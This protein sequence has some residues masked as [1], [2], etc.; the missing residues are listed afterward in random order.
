MYFKDQTHGRELIRENMEHLKGLFP[1]LSIAD[2]G[3]AGGTPPPYSLV[4]EIVD[5]INFEPDNRI[6]PK[7]NLGEIQQV[8][9]GPKELNK[10]YLNKRP[11]TSS[12]LP[13]CHRVVDRYDFSQFKDVDGKI[14]ETIGTKEVKTIGFDDALKQAGRSYPDFIK[15]DVQGLTLEVLESAHQSL[16][17]NTLG[18]QVEVEFLES[19]SNQHT[20]GDV[21]NLMLDHGFEIYS[22]QNLCKWFFK[23]SLPLKH[24]K[25]GQHTFCDLIYFRS[26]D[27]CHNNY[28]SIEKAYKIIALFLLNDLNDSA[29]AFFERFIAQDI[30]EKEDV[31]QWREIIIEWPGLMNY[32]Y[33]SLV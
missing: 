4:P 31:R 22:L 30:L 7:N 10:F 32:L 27:T 28:F 20:F 14:F 6:D 26:I 33:R 1:Q 11:F 13:P 5:V 3:S 19:Y 8:A 16:S 24:K 9:I 21:H 12:L 29:A 25:Q 2:L 15:I 23:T 17:T 18:V